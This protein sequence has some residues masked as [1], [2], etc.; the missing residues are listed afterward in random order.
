MPVLHHLLLNPS[1]KIL[2][3][4][5]NCEIVTSGWVP[6]LPVLPFIVWNAMCQHSHYMGYIGILPGITTS[7]TRNPPEEG[8][9]YTDNAN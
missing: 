2:I 8:D 6:V 5:N 9:L 7:W 3:V 1:R 4:A